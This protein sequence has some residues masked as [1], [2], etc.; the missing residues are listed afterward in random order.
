MA[1]MWFCRLYRKHDWGG[2]RK[3][4]VM[5]EDK[6]RAGILHGRS[7]TRDQG[8]PHTFKQPDLV[9]TH[10]TVPKGDGAKP[11]MGTPPS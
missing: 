2:L 8:V 3:L 10:Y 1:H 6:A 7:G 11:F 5:V 9:S 4:T